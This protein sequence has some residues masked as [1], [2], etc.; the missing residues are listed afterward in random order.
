M[1]EAAIE[2]AKVWADAAP[3]SPRALGAAASLLVSANRVD[4]AQPYLKRILA[5]S[6][7]GRGDGFLQINRLLANN[8]DKA[9]S[10]RAMQSLAVP[11]PTLAQARFA[12]AASAASAGEDD[13][14]LKEI[15]AASQLKPDWELAALFEAQ[16]LQK[17]SNAA[18]SE[19]LAQ[20]LKA[21]PQSR[22]V[23]WA[24]A[25]LVQALLD[26]DDYPAAREEA[27]K[28]EAMNPTGPLVVPT[29]LLISRWATEKGR[30]DEARKIASED[31]PPDQVDANMAYL[32]KM[33]SQ[34]NTWQ[35]LSD[36]S[37]G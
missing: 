21:Y 11:Y 17:K 23:V 18:A 33:L 35:Q 15:H 25:G 4:E 30:F 36:G 12:V 13:L 16:L 32:K 27:R 5:A 34:P 26:L 22:E 6:G 31:L 28:L 7:E 9:A 10:L 20:Y 37:T 24:R 1:P 19:R 14:A 3:D 8:P 29:R 2:S